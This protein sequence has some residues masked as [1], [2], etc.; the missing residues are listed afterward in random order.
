MPFIE[1]Y[2]YSESTPALQKALKRAGLS[3]DV[4]TDKLKQWQAQHRRWRKQARTAYKRKG[5]LPQSAEAWATM[6]LELDWNSYSLEYLKD[7]P[8]SA[9][10][11]KALAY[12]EEGLELLHD[13]GHVL[14]ISAARSPH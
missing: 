3:H 4:I 14:K 2:K 10:S 1:S 6:R 8:L 12:W 5:L 9:A 13:N 7:W 11:R